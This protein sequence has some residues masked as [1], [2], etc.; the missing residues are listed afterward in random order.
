M[1]PPFQLFSIDALR[2]TV[3]AGLLTAGFVCPA[4]ETNSSLPTIRVRADRP[5]R[6]DPSLPA[7]ST[8]ISGNEIERSQA[9]SV[10][11]LL[12]QKANLRFRS[13]TGK[14]S[15]GQI[16]MRGFGDNSGLRVHIEVD[17]Q[18]FNRPD[19]GTLD[20]NQ[21]PISDVSHIEVLRGGQTV[22]YGS[23][24]LAGVVNITTKKGGAPRLYLRSA[25]G[26]DDF[27]QYSAHASGGAGSWYADAGADYLH[28]PG[29]RS[30]SLSKAKTVHLS[31]GRFVADEGSLTLRAAH[32]KTYMQFP[33]PLTHEQMMEN[34]RQSSN[35]GDQYVAATNGLYTLLWDGEHD[36]G[37]TRL[38]AGYNHRDM[39]WTF[40]GVF[41]E[42]RQQGVSIA[43][44][45]Q[46]GPDNTHLILG[47]DLFYDRVD[48]QSFTDATNSDLNAQADLERVTHGPYGFAQFELTDSLTLSGGA[49]YENA[50]TDTRYVEYDYIPTT[51][52]FIDMPWGPEL[53]PDYDPN[54]VVR[55]VNASNS[56]SGIVS[57]E[58]WAVELSLVWKPTESLSL[59]AGWDRS[60]RYPVLDETVSYQG[61]PL[62]DPLNSQ[63]DP[64]EGD[65]Y[66][67]GIK[68]SDEH[69]LFSLTG[70]YLD[71]DDEILFDNRT[72][73]NINIGPTERIG[74]DIEAG[75]TA[76]RFGIHAR[77]DFVEAR[78]ADGP[79]KG[80]SIPLVPWAHGTVS[81]WLQPFDFLRL[82]AWYTHTA[83][84]YQGNDY[85]NENQRL[86]D[87]GLLGVQIDITV[88]DRA[89][90][91]VKGDN[92]LDQTYASSAYGNLYYPGTERRLI[93]GLA[94][95]LP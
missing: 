58:G 67:V 15:A 85:A 20:W 14:A 43:P 56:F 23:H 74:A 34:P 68:Y 27:E 51:K 65:G 3:V 72:N 57:K 19:M 7:D 88:F 6:I 47:W 62:R 90:V 11:D 75:W 29:F 50:R 77:C 21:I 66:E 81:G 9:A 82:S 10:P 2:S 80:R 31:L 39:N 64:E 89:T 44:R 93:V 4:A 78:F 30:N 42:N 18:K 8:L 26:S 12:E 59:W 76:E 13:S 17:G 46:F 83:P 84:Q 5:A 41:A 91:F 61:Y 32:G 33:G 86:R 49:R 37:R 79:D 36:W 87:Y 40:G 28:D 45:I 69:L 92:L 54:D 55:T 48:Y 35:P 63:L 25:A 70:Y 95:E 52:P 22:L 71:L 16:A 53:N 24:A 73:M 38:N 94:M 60:Y 1:R